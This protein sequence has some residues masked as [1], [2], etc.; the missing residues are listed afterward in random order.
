MSYIIDTPQ[1]IARFRLLQLKFALKLESLGMKHSSGR[2][3]TPIVRD[4]IGSKTRDKKLL[5]N[6]FTD[7]VNRLGTSV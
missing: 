4:I 5:L 1:G 3:V 7:Y 2:S 6:E